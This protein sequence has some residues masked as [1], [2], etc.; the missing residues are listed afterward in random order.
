MVRQ[1]YPRPP[2]LT[3]PPAH[4]NR[5]SPPPAR[6]AQE[7]TAARAEAHRLQ[8]ALMQRDADL[9]R[10]AVEVG[11]LQRDKVTLD[12]MLQEQQ[13]EQGELQARLASAADKVVALTEA[14]AALEARV[15]EA[16][17]AHSRL[18]LTQTRLEQE[19]AILEKG[20]AWLNEELG[21]KGDAFSA[22]RRKATDR[23]LELQSRLVDAESSAQRLQAENAALSDKCE[24]HRRAAEVRR[25]CGARVGGNWTCVWGGRGGGGQMRRGVAA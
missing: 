8:T 5:T 23:I 3:P 17:T 6:T 16:Q 25:V 9:E 19:K 10:R 4:P 18:Q 13:A 22:E 14:N 2:P 11:S 20:N 15:H 7:L 21:R 12:K 1:P 24:T